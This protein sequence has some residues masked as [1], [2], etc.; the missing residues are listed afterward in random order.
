MAS[1][2]AETNDVLTLVARILCNS[3]SWIQHQKHSS[4]QQDDEDSAVGEFVG[5]SFAFAASG[6][7]RARHALR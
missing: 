6:P 2:T 1:H 5:H 4:E 3:G 7:L